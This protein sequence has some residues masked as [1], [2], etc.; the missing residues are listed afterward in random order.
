M[1]R[2]RLIFNNVSEILGNEN[3]GIIILTDEAELQQIAIVCDKTTKEAINIRVKKLSE[4]KDMLPEILTEMLYAKGPGKYE[5]LIQDVDDG[6]YITV[7]SDTSNGDTFRIKASQA[8]LLSII[9]D[10]PIY[11]TEELMRKQANVFMGKEIKISLPIN[12]ITESMLEKSLEKAIED[13]NYEIASKIS[14][15]LNKRRNKDH[16]I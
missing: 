9:S 13:E 5:I 14:K 7:I 12:A 15:E 6:Q 16:N 3:I 10:I 11:I 8:I 2:V 1:N 4:T